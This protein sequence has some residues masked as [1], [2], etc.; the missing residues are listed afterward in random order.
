MHVERTID[1]GSRETISMT[2]IGGD[3]RL[4]DLDSLQRESK[5]KERTARA[6]RVIQ[7]GTCYQ[8]LY[9]APTSTWRRI[10][11]ALRFLVEGVAY[12]FG[13]SLD[14]GR[15][16]LLRCDFRSVGISVATQYE[17]PLDLPNNSCN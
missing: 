11:L 17:Y 4:V 16:I 8:P 1:G 13:R 9:L 12:G 5:G 14:T 15:S 10:S 2:L 6:Q 3:D 7:P